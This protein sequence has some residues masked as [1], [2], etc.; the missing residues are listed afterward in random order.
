MGTNGFSRV[1]PEMALHLS[2]AT[3]RTPESWPAMQNTYGLWVARQKIKNSAAL[4]RTAWI[5][6]KLDHHV[7]TLW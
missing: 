7:I 6:I 5:E 4:L 3:G 2:I 1:T